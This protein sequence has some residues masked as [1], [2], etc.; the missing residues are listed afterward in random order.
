M[1]WSQSGLIRGFSVLAVLALSLGGCAPLVNQQSGPVA[2]SPAQPTPAPEPA[3][4]RPAAETT[5]R[6]GVLLPLSGPQAALGQNLLDAAQLATFDLGGADFSLIPFDTLGTPAGAAAAA[7]Q[8]LQD[9]AGILVGPVF[10][11]EVEAVKV[12]AAP[13][14]VPVL[15]L[16][17]NSALADGQTFVLGFTPAEQV[18][19]ILAYAHTQGINRIAALIPSTPYGDQVEQALQSTAPQLGLTVTLAQR[20]QPAADPVATT[21]SFAPALGQAGGADAVLMTDSS[22][23]L[24]ALLQALS[25]SG[26]DFSR[27]RLLGTALWDEANLQRIPQLAGAWYAAPSA[28][29]RRIFAERYARTYSAAPAP[30]AALAYDAVAM[31]AV[32]SRQDQGGYELTRLTDSNGFAGATGTFRLKPTGLVEHGLEVREV[33]ADESRRREAAPSRFGSLTN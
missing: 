27:T 5:H 16:S 33:A 11:G 26:I 25:Q 17:N 30:I 19:R 3:P 4:T 32:L 7:R 23:G 21:A 24:P 10:S 8:A 15:A 6:V 14:R 1:Q 22:P 28:D 13:A 9:G 18:T 2:S 31:A 20:Y 12:V 29:S